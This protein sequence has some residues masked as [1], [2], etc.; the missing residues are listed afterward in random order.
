MEYF[1]SIIQ[2][3]Y[4]DG[5]IRSVYTDGITDGIFRIKK[6]GCSLTWKFLQAILSTDSPRD[7][8]RE[9]CTVTWP[10]HCQT[11][12]RNH[13]GIQTGIFVQWSGRFTVRIADESANRS[14]PSVIPSV[15]VNKWPLCQPSPSLFLHL[16][17]HPNSPLPN[18]K[19][20]APHKKKNLPLLSTSHISL[21]FVVIVSVFWFIDGFYYFL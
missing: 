10:I 9:I 15:K 11:Y 14:S 7:S 5:I 16:L 21:S 20:P 19:Q 17:L 4:T 6:M 1:L 3:L 8:N 12:R 2:S 18:Y 13:Q